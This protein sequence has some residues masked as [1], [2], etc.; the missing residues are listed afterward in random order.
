LAFCVS[1][2]F[3]SSCG[4]WSEPGTRPRGRFD[5]EKSVSTLNTDALS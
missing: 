2:L 3:V 5:R 4:A 1:F